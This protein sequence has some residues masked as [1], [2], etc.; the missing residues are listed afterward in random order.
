[1]TAT[2]RLKRGDLA[3]RS[4]CNLETIRYYETIGLMKSPERT[5]TGH[6]LYSKGDQQRLGFILRGRDLG[7]S[8]EE[9]KSLLTLVDSHEYTCGEVRDITTNHLASVRKKL[10]N[11]KRLESALASVAARCTGE[12]IPDC[13]V[14]DVLFGQP[15]DGKP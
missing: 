1:M 2:Q 12:D 4:G 15:G 7:F 14:I 5:S 6:R 10:K 11:L 8:I 13:P 9:L 3:K